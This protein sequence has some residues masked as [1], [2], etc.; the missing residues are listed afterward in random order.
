MRRVLLGAV[1]A[2][3]CGVAACNGCDET[4]INRVQPARLV[5]DPAALDFG[6]VPLGIAVPLSITLSN[7][8]E[9]TAVV[10]E[11]AFRGAINAYRVVDAPPTIAAKES[12]TVR[13]EFNPPAEGTAD[14][15]LL[16]R[17]D[18][19]A[20]PEV[21]V[22]LSGV[23]IPR[24]V[25]GSCNTPP[26]NYC[27]TSAV[28][29]TYRSMGSCVMGQCRYDAERTDC[30]GACVAAACVSAPVDGGV[31]DAS[32]PDAALPPDAG[33][34]DAGAPDAA[35]PPDAGTQSGVFTVP[36]EHT[37]VVPAGVTQ[38]NVDSWGGGGAGGEQMESTGGGAGFTRAR[39]PVTPG[40]T[41]LVWVAEGAVAPGNGGGA[42][43]VLRGATVL[44]VAAGG[45]GGGSDGCSGCKA[46]GRGG[47]GG[48]TAGEA[49]AALVTPLAPFCT[50]ATGGQGGTAAMGGAGGAA[51]G[52]AF[53][54]VGTPGASLAGGRANGVNNSCNAGVGA[55]GWRMGG[56]QGNG[57]GGGGGAGYFGGG[58]AGFIW[59]YCAGGGGGG[60]SYA[61][62]DAQNVILQAGAIRTQGNPNQSEG[63]GAGGDV[64][65]GGAN[66]RVV[67]TL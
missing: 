7:T 16:I 9:T 4:G 51:T 22:P 40:E 58:G 32:V 36:G 23:G 60:S 37:Y 28:L 8:G 41:L 25:C 2:G 19:D 20:T 45:G 11:F 17:S 56:G 67:L 12:A 29:I 47:A 6:R 39:L 54:C 3:L 24:S 21:S 44:A 57:G 15:T 43:A 10:A 38:L 13:V 5:P 26:S 53:A 61:A 48:G 33:V 59:T 18:A 34:P 31:R 49:G 63:A 35:G 62:P 64:N 55:E 66:G 27:A 50:S 65:R 46:G 42:S 14:A 52:T 1:V 30:S